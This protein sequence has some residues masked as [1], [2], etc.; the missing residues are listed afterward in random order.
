VGFNEYRPWDRYN[1][2]EWLGLVF[3][4]PHL[5]IHQDQS[6]DSVPN[7]TDE[8]DYLCDND[9]LSDMLGTRQFVLCR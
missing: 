8:K 6:S 5:P 9:F 4:A 2:V 3:G 1:L 7:K